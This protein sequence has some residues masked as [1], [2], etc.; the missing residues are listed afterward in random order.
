MLKS[1]SIFG[2]L[3]LTLALSPLLA[4]SDDLVTKDQLIEKL[5]P[6]LK[7]KNK[8]RSLS[9]DQNFGSNSAE[10]EE[11][12]EYEEDTGRADL[13]AIQFEYN[14]DDL[15][16]TGQLQVDEL[17]YAMMAL[18][19]ESFHLIGHT[20]ATGTDEYNMILSQRRADSVLNYL[21]EEHD[22]DP[23]RIET[24]G[25]GESE[26]V[27]LDD[28]SAAENRRVEAVNSSVFY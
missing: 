11:Y 25:V 13:S 7:P 23:D 18:D 22:I 2:I 8:T 5:V 1:Y 21:V 9:G 27:N 24:I 17:A 26:L 16:E 10:E 19:S 12:E 6:K 14:S 28:P 4:N 15:T 20:D 3:A